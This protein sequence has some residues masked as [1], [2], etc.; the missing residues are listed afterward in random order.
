M[1]Q[2]TKTIITIGIAVIMAVLD[3]WSFPTQIRKSLSRLI[4]YQC[5]DC[6]F[7][8]LLKKIDILA[9]YLL[10]LFWLADFDGDY[11]D[12][13][14]SDGVNWHGDRRMLISGVQTDM[15]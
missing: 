12:F 4:K 3:V 10:A 1:K 5:K 14:V 2:T 7:G 11:D 6:D 8:P 13:S 9:P 15:V